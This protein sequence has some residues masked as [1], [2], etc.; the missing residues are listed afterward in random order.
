MHGADLDHQSRSAHDLAQPVIRPRDSDFLS[1]HRDRRTARG[2]QSC[3]GKGS[4]CVLLLLL[5]L[6]V[7]VVVLLLHSARASPPIEWGRDWAS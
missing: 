1:S 7:V 3:V 4:S 6:L 5:L 2:E